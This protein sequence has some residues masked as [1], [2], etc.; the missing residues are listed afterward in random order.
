M[1]KDTGHQDTLGFVEPVD[2]QEE[3]ERSFL[4]YA[5][6]VIVS[7]AL[8]DARD[9]LKP[10][11]RRI[12]YGMYVGGMRPD[13]PAGLEPTPRRLTNVGTFRAYILNYLEAHPGVHQRMTLL[14]RQLEPGP[15]GLPLEI[16]CFSK[17]TAWA[18]YE[19][20]QSDLFDHFI[21]IAPEFGLRIFQEP[22]GSDLAGLAGR[23]ER[24]TTADGAAAGAADRTNESTEGTTV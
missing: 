16:Y 4:D 22:A 8:P 5:M 17:D 12:L 21:A 7:R 6:S 15:A 9:G 1:A 19:G 23:A 2:I 3:M 14:V 20:L 13:R 18:V 11:Q 24:G 10:V